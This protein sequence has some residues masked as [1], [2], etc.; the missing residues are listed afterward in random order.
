MKMYLTWMNGQ[1]Q[2]L[3]PLPH[4][5]AQPAHNAANPGA[6]QNAISYNGAYPREQT[7]NCRFTGVPQRTVGGNNNGYQTAFVTV[8][9]PSRTP[10]VGQPFPVPR[11]ALPL[12]NDAPLYRNQSN[13]LH[14]NGSSGTRAF[15]LASVRHTRG[16]QGAYQVANQL[17]SGNGVFSATGTALQVRQG[18]GGVTSSSASNIS[19]VNNAA[20]GPQP[21]AHPGPHRMASLH[22]MASSL[23]PSRQ[24]SHASNLNQKTQ[25]FPT[26][27]DGTKALGSSAAGPRHD[28]NGTRLQASADLQSTTTGLHSDSGRKRTTDKPLHPLL[29]Q[30]LLASLPQ[31]ANDKSNS[32][33]EVAV[34]H[35]L[36][37][38]CSQ[39]SVNHASKGPTTPGSLSVLGADKQNKTQQELCRTSP[40]ISSEP[41]LKE[42]QSV[43]VQATRLAPDTTDQC[44]QTSARSLVTLEAPK[45]QEEKSK[46]KDIP[47]QPTA[48]N[49]QLSSLPT[50]PWTL[51]ELLAL[52]ETEGPEMPPDQPKNVDL[53]RQLVS[54]FWDKNF[55]KL[56]T[57]VQTTILKDIIQDVVLYCV[58]ALKEDSVVLSQVQPRDISQ[59]KSASVLQDG[60]VYS[61]VPYSS[62][63]LNQ[64]EQLD[65]IDKEFGP[66]VY[67]LVSAKPPDAGPTGSVPSP[68]G[69]EVPGSQAGDGSAQSD[70]LYSFQIQV[71]PPEEAKAV[72]DQCH[73]VT[74]HG[75]PEPVPNPAVADE[76]LKDVPSTRG[77]HTET[78][79]QQFCCIE[80]WK[81]T[82]CGSKASLGKCTCGQVS[83][84][85][86]E[87]M[88]RQDLMTLPDLHP[89]SPLESKSE[90]RTS[91]PVSQMFVLRDCKDETDDTDK[92]TLHKSLPTMV[93]EHQDT[94]VCSTEKDLHQDQMPDYEDCEEAQLEPAESRQSTDTDISEEETPV[95]PLDG[96]CEEAPKASSD[97]TSSSL[98]P[99]MTCLGQ[100]GGLTDVSQTPTQE[101]DSRKRKR[102]SSPDTLFPSLK[103]LIQTK[104]RED[105]RNSKSRTSCVPKTD[106]EPSGPVKTVQLVLFG[107]LPRE[108][109]AIS[110]RCQE[111]AMIPEVVYA[112]VS[113]LK[114]RP[115]KAASALDYSAAKGIRAKMLLSPGK[116]KNR[117]KR[118]AKTTDRQKTSSIKGQDFGAHLGMSAHDRRR[119]NEHGSQALFP[120]QE[121]V[122]KF[123][124]L[125]NSFSFEDS[126]G[127]KETTEGCPDKPSPESKKE[128]L[129]QKSIANVWNPLPGKGCDPTQHH[130][131][132]R[133]SGV[134]AVF[135]KKYMEM[136]Q[137]SVTR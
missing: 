37:P 114:S 99:E 112:N 122:L 77:S 126:K 38:P 43:P 11:P 23:P 117:L 89:H 18:V 118:K 101:G 33:R 46:G 16:H 69:S 56:L 28:S 3:R 52:L 40:E 17:V 49:S 123:N 5:S 125:P 100:T 92:E 35:P 74:L 119:M 108:R 110:Q 95:L 76:P 84:L 67:R 79:L 25:A 96:K 50:R 41:H 31:K 63:W 130:A 103:K 6:N 60:E 39:G 65:D 32:L 128:T 59:L 129:H 121:N 115:G 87:P 48:G 127:N 47:P 2:I 51:K 57:F 34:V 7:S 120:I 83:D 72:F 68:P 111:T 71:L 58:N 135:Q 124:V 53:V 80:K 1:F 85:G 61:E 19:L 90:K 13:T 27:S 102:L 15:S 109:R 10:Q 86:S 36:T 106:C 22:N 104:A 73:G 54:L 4:P 133:S 81:E 70:P 12:R 26:Q 82:V 42:C 107:S 93:V 98:E 55:G 116:R 137:L 94:N 113:P 131:A 64:N 78:S 132:P 21:S 30:L 44:G 9:N 97:M 24:I 8:Q 20:R 29:T 91:M 88:D 62:S 14:C 45:G 105:S 75:D 66:N 134:F 136:S